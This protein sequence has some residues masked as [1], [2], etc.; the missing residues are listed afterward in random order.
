MCCLALAGRLL[1]VTFGLKTMWSVMFASVAMAAF[2]LC[3]KDISLFF[4]LPSSVV[5]YALALFVFGFS[6]REELNR[7]RY[8]LS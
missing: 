1:D 6:S 4:V 3:L 2:I 7:L 5:V 8:E